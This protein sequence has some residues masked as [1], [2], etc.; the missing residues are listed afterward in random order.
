[1][2]CS[3]REKSKSLSFQPA[4]LILDEPFLFHAGF[5][6]LV[7]KGLRVPEDISLICTDPDPTFAWCRP[8]VA[9]INWDYNLVVRRFI[10]WIN[11]LASGKE[12]RR[13]TFTKAEYVRGGT[14][15]LALA[16]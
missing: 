14:V 8:T 16:R 5:H 1:M 7:R 4:S 2:A 3:Y 10:R 15:G 13:Q 9:H 11:N 6:H 12:D